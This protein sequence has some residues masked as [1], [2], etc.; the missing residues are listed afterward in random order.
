MNL[1]LSPSLTFPDPSLLKSR[2]MVALLWSARMN[3][4]IP[5]SFTTVNSITI[6]DLGSPSELRRF[7]INFILL[8]LCWDLIWFSWLSGFNELWCFVVIWPTDSTRL[9]KPLSDIFIFTFFKI[10]FCWKLLIQISMML[11]NFPYYFKVKTAHE[12][13]SSSCDF[14]II[15]RIFLGKP[16]NRRGI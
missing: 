11:Y 14:A 3:C 9:I 7:F 2:I 6:T 1:S 8:L 10:F 4:C 16:H 5:R 12:L 13:W 15:H